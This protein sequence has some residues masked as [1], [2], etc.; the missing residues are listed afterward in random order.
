MAARDGQQATQDLVAKLNQLAAQT[1]GLVIPV[2]NDPR[3]STAAAYA[4]WDANPCSPEKANAVVTA[5]NEVVDDVR[6]QGGGLNQLRSIVTIGPDELA[7][8][9]RVYDG[10]AVGN[11]SDYGDG[12]TVDR[13]GDGVRDDDAVS[14]ALRLGYLLTD[15][16]YGDFDPSETSFVPDVALGR[17]LESPAQIQDQVQ[18]FLDSNGVVTPQRSFV[19]GY[20]FLADGANEMFGSLSAATPGGANSSQ[21]NETWTA[22]DA[23]PAPTP[24]ARPSSASTLTTTTT[25]RCRPTPST[26]PARTCSSPHR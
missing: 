10:T 23:S 9:A 26:A 14:A 18:A 16:P 8:F 7:P 24:P 5:I 25:A 22:A 2:D 21:I 13:N 17:L 11:E 19:T 15:D 6:Q 1:N 12:A 4:A 20:D 3:V